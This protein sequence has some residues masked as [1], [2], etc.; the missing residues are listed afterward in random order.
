MNNCLLEFF[1]DYPDSAYRIGYV[2]VRQLGLLV[3]TAGVDLTKGASKNLNKKDKAKRQHADPVLALLSWPFLL[4]SRLWVDAVGR[5]SNLQGLSFPLYNV[6]TSAL[7]MKLSSLAYTPF[8]LHCLELLC[9]L[10]EGTSQFVPI[11][12]YSFA[13]VKTLSSHQERLA[14][15]KSSSS[16]QAIVKP[17]DIDICVRIG[18]QQADILQVAE[19]LLSRWVQIL[20]D[21]MGLLARH[22]SFPEASFPL[23]CHLRKTARVCRSDTCR[24]EMKALIQTAE[25]TAVQI[26]SKRSDLDLD[27]LPT[28]KLLFYGEKETALSQYRRTILTSRHQAFEKK[29]ASEVQSAPLPSKHAEISNETARTKK[30]SLKSKSKSKTLDGIKKTSNK[31]Q[32][33]H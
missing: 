32:R 19:Q 21:H 10:S 6:L 25:S 15:K 29:I 20:V 14:S 2:S 7:K 17:V 22:P 26:R 18:P 1:A 8:S 11:G 30:R 13:L 28:G 12:A 4:C 5:S 16:K 27:K 3:R 9:T 23:I 24:K 33:T 31:K